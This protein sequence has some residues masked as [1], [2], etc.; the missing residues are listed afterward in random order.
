MSVRDA[1]VG[2]GSKRVLEHFNVDIVPGS[3]VCLLGPNGVGK[4]TLFKSILGLQPMLGGNVLLDGDD[5]LK[6]P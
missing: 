4:T 5:A 3:V 1:S 2:Y 6:M